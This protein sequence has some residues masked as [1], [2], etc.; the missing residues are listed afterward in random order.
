VSR[1]WANI[2]KRT[3]AAHVVYLSVQAGKSKKEV[4][5]WVLTKIWRSVAYAG[6]Q[7]LGRPRREVFE[8]EADVGS[9]RSCHMASRVVKR[10]HV[11]RC[12][13][14]ELG[15]H[16]V[17]NVWGLGASGIL[18]QAR[19]P[20]TISSMYLPEFDDVLLITSPSRE[21]GR[22]SKKKA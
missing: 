22:S 8:F 6:E 19:Q 20:T 13:D 16:A 15:A 11:Q 7:Q 12:T 18:A 17:H 3:G 9:G 14:S 21:R 10:P 5:E 2:A 1:P 4:V